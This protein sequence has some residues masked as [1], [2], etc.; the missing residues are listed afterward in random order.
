M[1]YHLCVLD[2]LILENQRRSIRRNGRTAG[3]KEQIA[4]TNG[5]EKNDGHEDGNNDVPRS[6]TSE[7]SVFDNQDEG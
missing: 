1:F 7:S 6:P 2:F 5:D 3:G 4:S